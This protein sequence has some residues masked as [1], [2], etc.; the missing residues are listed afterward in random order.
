MI[1]SDVR[2]S[3]ANYGSRR[4]YSIESALLEKRLIFDSSM[5]SGKKTMYTLT[6]LQSCYDRQLAEIGGILEESIGKDRSAMKVI[7]KV[8]PKWR[9]FICTG[10]GI[11]AMYYGGV[12]NI[13]AGTGQ[14][15]RFSG[16]VCRDLSCLIIKN[17][18]Q[19]GVGM[20]IKSR[21]YN[22]TIQ[23]VAVAFVDDN[24]MISDGD[25]VQEKMNFIVTEYNDLHMA[26]GGYMEEE[27]SK[28]YAYQ[29]IIKS[30]KKTIKN[31]KERVAINGIELEKVDCTKNV[32]TLGV[33]MGPSIT[34]DSQFVEMVN[35]MKDAISKLKHTEIFVSTASMYYNMYLCKKV[36]YGSGIVSINKHQEEILRKIY[37][38]VLLKKMGLSEKFPRTVLYS[39]KTSLG[40]GLMTP[41]TIM[42]SLALKLYVGHKRYKSELAT[43]I[44]INEE[45]ARV[46]YGYSKSIMEVERR[47]KPEK[48]IWSDEIQD[49]LGKRNLQMINC[50]QEKKWISKNKTIMDYAIEYVEQ[51]ELTMKYTEAI[52]HVRIYKRMIL[53]CELTGFYGDKVTKEAREIFE[54][55]SLIW[56][57][58]FENV[59]KPHKKLI[60]IWREFIEWIKLQRIETVIDFDGFVSTKYEISPDQKWVKESMDNNVKYYELG[61]RRYGRNC[62][63]Q[64]EEIDNRSWRKCIAE[65]S[66]SKQLYL[67][68]M[69]PPKE[70]LENE[71]ESDPLVPFDSEVTNSIMNKTLYAAT[72]AS[73]KDLKMGGCWIIED[74]EKTF[75]KER[76]V[77][78][79]RWDENSAGSAEVSVLLELIEV[80]AHKGKHIEEGEI[81]IGFDNRKMFKRL[82]S[83]IRRNSVYAQE[84]GAEISRI[85]DLLATIKFSVNIRLVK[86]SKDSVDQDNIRQLKDLLKECDE[87]AGKARIEIES[88][89]TITNLK[90]YGNYA[91]MYQGVIISRSIQETLRIIDAKNNEKKYGDHKLGY[92]YNFVDTE[93]RN[94]F[95]TQN[96]TTSMI[97]CAHGF[98][99]FGLRDSLINNKMA[100]EYCPRCD[101][102]ETWDHVVKCSRTIEKRKK[103]IQS[104]LLEMLQNREDVAVNDIMSMCEDI[105]CYLENG[106]EDEYETNQHYV[107]M[108]EVFRGYAISNWTATDFNS[109][110]YRK[111]NKILVYKCVC[112]YNECW[113]DR[114]NVL[115][116]ENKQRER[117][118][119]WYEKEKQKAESSQYRQM[120][121]YVQRC[122]IDT[123]RCS[124]ETIKKWIVNLKEIERKVE[125]IPLDDIRRWMIT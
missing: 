92:K 86:S 68:S 65:M 77:Y 108:K 61:E 44:R 47:Y 28:Y 99:H 102:I 87:K 111:L 90:Y 11:S 66:P 17:I 121:L 19:R 72:D 38:P 4:N 60:E 35:K 18:E 93:A 62:Y 59:R 63:N 8:I 23:K 75:R 91:L 56:N 37:E 40:V 5:M 123:D 76:I 25:E 116:D 117:L 27:K 43:I 119:K 2:F 89:E 80:I 57:I 109:T 107:G 83:P 49:I 15:N 30:G 100:E 20:K 104:M 55:S 54:T 12:N 69:F 112:Y 50:V 122:K 64:V 9:H 113:K 101:M 42:S 3:K 98:N 94:V 52:N 7:T 29:W 79:K 115:H 48:I 32:K 10:F 82:T 106:R 39:R 22:D 88:F 103:F 53:P 16:D 1:E 14:G 84:S 46:F 105:L 34:W 33:T 118:K 24:D 78:H 125:K 73:V 114:N 41:N 95:K 6:D 26:T 51:N 36:F 120:N 71:N 97:K 13:L 81:V 96:V 21:V 85:Q 74:K 110:K 58:D 31:I 124:C 67:Y 45:N 70:S